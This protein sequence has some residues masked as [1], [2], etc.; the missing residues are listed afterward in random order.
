[1]S[2]LALLFVMLAL[3]FDAV[4]VHPPAPPPLTKD[5]VPPERMEAMVAAPMALVRQGRLEAADALFRAEL[6]R[7]AAMDPSRRTE[8]DL[9]TAYG[10]LLFQEG[11]EARDD[12]RLRRA[13]I[14][15]LRQ[16]VE[17]ARVGWGPRH[18]ETALA[19]S[20]LGDALSGVE[21]DEVPAEAER[22]L[23][24]AYDIRVA[25]LGPDNTETQS[26]RKDL[27]RVRRARLRARSPRS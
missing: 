3:L 22:A 26:T 23:A 12:P 9:L 24:E 2:P 4:R 16:A 1:M 14:P 8:S 20:D 5:R 21:G 18:P 25:T 7:A 13:A 27:D 10:V 6:A 15:W 17:A 19:L 11:T